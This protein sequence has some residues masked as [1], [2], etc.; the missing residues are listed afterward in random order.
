METKSPV[1]SGRLG[2]SA[3]W[4]WAIFS[5]V[6]WPIKSYLR[7]SILFLIFGLLSL[8]AHPALKRWANIVS[9]LRDCCGVALTRPFA[10]TFASFRAY[11]RFP[12]RLLSLPFPLTFPSPRRCLFPH[13]GLHHSHQ[14]A[15]GANSLQ[16]PDGAF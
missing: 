5:T 2:P 16:V 11:F 13:I 4:V 10:L 1:R 12:S 7:S 6:V 9:S 14:F 15:H 3:R 8:P